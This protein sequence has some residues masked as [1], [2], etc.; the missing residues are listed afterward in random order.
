MPD[1]INRCNTEETAACC[2][3][4]VGTVIDN[5]D[6]TASYQCFFASEQE[7]EL[8][9]NALI[10]KAKEVESDPCVIRYNI[11]AVEGGMQ[12]SV[13]FTFSC[14]AEALIFQL[15]LR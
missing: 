10:K 15:G 12:L 14:Q 8:M 11:E 2:C 5:E 3:V 13:D 9:L 6:C 7:A 1:A 4:D